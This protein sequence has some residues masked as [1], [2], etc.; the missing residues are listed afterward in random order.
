[1]K[2]ALFHRDEFV[3]STSEEYRFL[4]FQ[5][6]RRHNGDYLLTNDVGELLVLPSVKFQLFTKKGLAKNDPAYLDLKARHFLVD[7]GSSAHMELLAAKYHTKKSFLE[8]FTKLHIFVTTLRC[9]QSCQYCQVSRRNE[10][11]A[12]DRFDMS[13]EVLRR[14][15]EL[16]LCSPAAHITMEFQGGEP[17]V[18]FGL[19]KEAVLLTKD[20]NRRVGKHIDYVLCTNLAPLKDEHLEF[21][22]EHEILVSTSL[23]GPAVLHDQNR[24]SSQG[25]ASHEIVTRNIRRAQ[26]ALGKHAVSALMTT[27]RASLKFSREIIDEYLRMDM[28]S[29]FLR[30]L[31]PFG[32]AVKTKSAIGYTSADFMKFYKETLAYIIE[33]NRQGRTFSEAFASMVL[34]KAF[35]PWPIGFVDLQSPSGAG[36]GVCVYNYDGDVYASDESRMLAEAGDTT[37]RMGNVLEN[38]YDD[39]FFGET[40]QD[41]AAASCN[42][43]LAGCADCV[44]QSYC[45]AD[46][47]R[48]H[49]TQRDLYGNRAEVGSFCHR[50]KPLIKSVVDLM[51][52]ADEDLERILWAWINRE[53]VNR[54]RLGGCNA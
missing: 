39:I 14:S 7:G 29:V 2:S 26:E 33:I 46:P 19:V 8:G 42:E 34:T 28:G 24:P 52:D 31:N 12:A 20:L 49:R 50:N 15:V 4:P 18:N 13:R 3:G 35:T 25:K 45:G 53:D 27:T 36:M 43:A 38:S 1:M 22:K 30:E 6:D 48:N 32:F 21:L 23:D 51:L 5:F 10:G 47:V 44:Y 37:F 16:M 11:D 40:M 9:N 41:I 17:L 54:M